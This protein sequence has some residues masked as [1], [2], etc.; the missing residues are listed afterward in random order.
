MTA[1]YHYFTDPILRAPTIGSMLMCLTAALVGVLVFLRKRSLL[2]ETL[3]HATYPGVTLAVVIV[4]TMLSEEWLAPFILVGAFISSLLGL[5]AVDALKKYFNVRDDSALCFVLAS[6]FG[7]GLT[8]A[9]RVQFSHP[10]EYRQIQSYLY[11]QAATMTDFHILLYG[12]L[13]ILVIAIGALFYKEFKIT[14]FDANYAKS[15]GIGVRLF[16]SLLFLLIVI[17]VVVGIKSVG[18]V[19]MSAMLIA[20]A[21]AARQFSNRM[22]RILLIAGIIGMVSG[23]LGNYLSN[24]FSI[25]LAESNRG[26]QGGI[27]GSL[28]T[29]PSIVVVSGTICFLSL[30]FAPERGLIPRYIRIAFFRLRRL[31]ENLLK[32]VWR[33]NLDGEV[34]LSEILSSHSRSKTSLQL[35]LWKLK[36]DGLVSKR[37]KKVAL[38]SKGRKKASHIVRLHRLWEVYLVNSLGLGVERVH[39]NAEEME[40]IITPDLE[41]KLTEL[42]EDPLEDPHKQPIPRNGG[43]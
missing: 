8:I 28:P 21:A 29:G 36:W 12:V 34:E 13:S 43:A 40:H 1:I 39:R 11:G 38:T 24:E 31:E 37:G 42:L 5:F 16:D 33:I 9:S 32:T 6:F 15:L 30:L 27:R 17:S 2:G 19:L 14:T 35:C 10:Q 25:Y 3:S 4:A 7:I 22:S 23:F 41:K 26:I 20:P 18:V